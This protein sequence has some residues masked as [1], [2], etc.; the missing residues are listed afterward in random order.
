MQ[1]PEDAVRTPLLTLLM[2]RHEQAVNAARLDAIAPHGTAT[3]RKRHIAW[4]TAEAAFAE[5]IAEIP[6]QPDLPLSQEIPVL[7]LGKRG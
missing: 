4:R 1:P 7:C 6:C 5:S 3:S 2:T